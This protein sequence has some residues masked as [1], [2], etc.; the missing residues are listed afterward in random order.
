MASFIKRLA[1]NIAILQTEAFLS[2][3]KL[4]RGPASGYCPFGKPRLALWSNDLGK[5]SPNWFQ[6]AATWSRPP[7]FSSVR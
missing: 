6:P 5:C 2:M 1:F 3:Q 7:R 4:G